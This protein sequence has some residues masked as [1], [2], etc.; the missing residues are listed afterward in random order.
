MDQFLKIHKLPKLTQDEKDNLSS[1]LIILK[2]WI[3]SKKK[4]MF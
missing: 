3:Q 4:K 2:N 1:P